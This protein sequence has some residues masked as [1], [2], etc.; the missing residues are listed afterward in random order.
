MADEDYSRAT[1]PPVRG[2]RLIEPNEIN[3]QSNWRL[4][5]RQIEPGEMDTR[6]LVRQSQNVALLEIHMD[7]ATH[8]RGYSPSDAL[9]VGL[10]FTPTLRWWLGTE[11]ESPGLVYFGTAEEFDGVSVSGF[12]AL[13]VSV[14]KPFLAR[15]ADQIGLPLQDDL[16]GRRSLPLGRSSATINR[17]TASGRRLLN[18]FGTPFGEPEQEDFTA[19]L[20]SAMAVAETFEDRSTP[21]TRARSVRRALDY[22]VDR[23]DDGVSVG[24]ICED[25][26]ASWR[27]LDRGFR[28]Q[29]GIGPKAYLNRLRLS[30]VRSELLRKGVDTT[31]ADA[32]NAWDFW[33]MGQFAKDYCRM[34]GELPSETLR[35]ARSS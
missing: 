9:T 5:F 8:Q 12:A 16:R 15:V 10:P 25:V 2:C 4:D 14:S 27:T 29:F 7:R 30:R 1:A 6:I 11:V 26:G 34:F 24:A 31:I 28:E 23:A 17:L 21:S 3:R 13:T 33:H 32:A 20:I 35:Y 18:G 19:A 22:L